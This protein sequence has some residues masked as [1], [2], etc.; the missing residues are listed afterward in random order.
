MSIRDKQI[1]EEKVV[2]SVEL[3][4]KGQNK[5]KSEEGTTRTRIRRGERLVHRV[6]MWPHGRVKTN[7]V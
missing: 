4:Y 7:V 6:E 5:N 1:R 2:V 3:L